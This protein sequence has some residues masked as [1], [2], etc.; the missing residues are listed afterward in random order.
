[1]F[2]IISCNTE[3]SNSYP[4]YEVTIANLSKKGR[5]ISI[6]LYKKTNKNIKSINWSVSAFP[7]E[8]LSKENET[9]TLNIKENKEF[10]LYFSPYENNIEDI[11]KENIFYYEIY[12]EENKLIINK[13]I[14]IISNYID[15][16]NKHPWG[17]I[18]S[19]FKIENEKYVK[20]IRKEGPFIK[21]EF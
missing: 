20:E 7:E 15:S 10:T 16:K 11:G 12:D 2:F 3:E 9:V 5:K 21:L 13:K 17:L 4:P 18:A 19:I 14:T 1:M 8:I 6:K